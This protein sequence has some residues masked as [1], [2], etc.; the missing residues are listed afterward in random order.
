MRHL[1]TEMLSSDSMLCVQVHYSSLSHPHLPC[2]SHKAGCYISHF[3]VMGTS[4]PRFYVIP[5]KNHL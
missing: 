3:I 1:A 5:Q 2:A 4:V